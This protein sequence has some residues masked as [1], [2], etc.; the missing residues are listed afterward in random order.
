MSVREQHECASGTTPAIAACWPDGM[1]GTHEKLPPL[2]HRPTQHELVL[3]GS[4]PA[5]DDLHE[6][7]HSRFSPQLPPQQSPPLVQGSPL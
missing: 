6:P 3:V 1:H 5:P 2:H 4:H 7:T